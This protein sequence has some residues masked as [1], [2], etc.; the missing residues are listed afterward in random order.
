MTILDTPE[1]PA[2]TRRK[3][4]LVFA[5]LARAAGILIVVALAGVAVFL[6]LEGLSL[7][8]I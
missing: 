1:A 2:T 3:G 4:D 8:H 7:I 5:S 6:T